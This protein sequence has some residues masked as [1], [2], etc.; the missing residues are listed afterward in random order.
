MI[1]PL[2]V[3]SNSDDSRI[4]STSSLVST[5]NPASADTGDVCYNSTDN[6]LNVYDLMIGLEHLMMAH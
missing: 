2:F 5:S 3:G 4:R 1:A 6:K